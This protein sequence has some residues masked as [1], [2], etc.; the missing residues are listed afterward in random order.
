MATKTKKT[1]IF[2][3]R[4]FDI[5]KAYAD[6]YWGYDRQRVENPDA[7]AALILLGYRVLIDHG[8][9]LAACAAYTALRGA[10]NYCDKAAGGRVP[11]GLKRCNM[12]GVAF[13]RFTSCDCTEGIDY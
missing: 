9:D 3:D 12:C 11:N 6:R 2:E 5:V 1:V 10:M 7:A 13:E 8:T 4:L